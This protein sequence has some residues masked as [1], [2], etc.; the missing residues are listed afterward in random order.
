MKKFRKSKYKFQAANAYMSLAC[1]LQPIPNKHR[2]NIAVERRVKLELL[3]N[4]FRL[5]HA[6]KQHRVKIAEAQGGKCLK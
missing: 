2:N 5:P 3:L 6:S 4:A 1:L